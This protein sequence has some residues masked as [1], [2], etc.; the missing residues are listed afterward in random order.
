MN[1][2]TFLRRATATTMLGAGGVLGYTWRFEPHWVEIVHRTLPIEHLPNGLVGRRLVQISDLHIG[3]VVDDAYLRSAIGLIE[4]L[5]PDVVAITG[6]LMTCRQ[7]EQVDRTLRMLESLTHG[8]LATVAVLGNHDYG[9]RAL[10]VGV[11]DRLALGLDNLG[12][13]TLRNQ[14]VDV[15]GLQIAGI[16]DLWSPRFDPRAAMEMLD[17]GSARLVLCHNPDAADIDVWSGYRGWILS[18]HT[19][20]GQCSVPLFGPPILPVRNKRYTAGA[21]DLHDGRMLY[22]NRGLGYARRVRFNARPE[23]TTFTLCRPAQ[24]C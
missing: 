23:I 9:R 2:R 11:A 24:S 20:G 7:G 15:G 19:H 17:D 1:R 13:R 6:D 12:I 4:R 21:I 16:D 18:G 10:Q 8:E 14:C 22:I 3:P 5:Q